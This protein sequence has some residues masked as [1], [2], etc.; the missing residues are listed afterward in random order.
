[1]LRSRT[2]A[3]HVIKRFNLQALY[4]EPTLVDTRRRLNDLLN[5]SAGKDG[6]ISIE[7]DDEDPNRSAEIANAFV[8]QLDR[9]T[10]EVAVTTAGRQRV[11][12]E[13]QL[14]QAKDQLSQAE[15]ALRTTQEE[16]GLIS[17][18]EQGKAMIESVANLRA[19]IAA[20]QVQLVSLGSST[21]EKNPDYIRARTELAGLQ[22]ELKKLEQN[23]PSESSTIIPS[24]GAIP[25]AG[26]EY[27][28][29]FRDVQFAQALYEILLK[30]YEIAKSQEAAESGVIQVLDRAI[31]PDKKSKPLRS[32]IV[33]ATTIIAGLIGTGC[34]FVIEA[35]HRLAANPDTAK[36]IAEV[37]RNMR[38]W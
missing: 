8:D 14:R 21:T 22:R 17:V 28:R 36:L 38:I 37:R 31:A 18:T 2:I 33:L 25:Q 5:V 23:A 16:T 20:K 19:M 1:M 15:I 29:R 6:I 34:A 11:F 7:F 3:D 27:V 26:L 32:L 35:R 12:L 10:Q 4:D 9:L 13:K 24:A 30:Q